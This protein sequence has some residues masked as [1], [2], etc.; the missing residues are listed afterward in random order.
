MKIKNIFASKKIALFSLFIASLTATLLIFTPNRAIAQSDYQSMLNSV[1][2]SSA[3]NCKPLGSGCN[4]CAGN[5][6]RNFIQQNR[7][8]NQRMQQEIF[9]AAISGCN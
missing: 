3:S 8:S 9:N 7:I 2:E 5:L 6:A 1:R 4:E